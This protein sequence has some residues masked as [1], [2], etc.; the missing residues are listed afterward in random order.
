MVFVERMGRRKKRGE[1]VVGCYGNEESFYEWRVGEG[2]REKKRER[3]RLL[4][5]K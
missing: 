2:K 3:E 4:H 1:G 5:E